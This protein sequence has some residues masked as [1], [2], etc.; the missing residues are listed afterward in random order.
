[1]IFNEIPNPLVFFFDPSKKS[2][3]T[4]ILIKAPLSSKLIVISQKFYNCKRVEY[5]TRI[6]AQTQ[7]RPIH[8][9]SSNPYNFYLT[10]TILLFLIHLHSIRTV[11]N[12]TKM[13]RKKTRAQWKREQTKTFQYQIAPPFP[14]SSLHRP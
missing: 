4:V 6:P 1:M 14:L 8:N 5:I 2:L 7:T 12:P 11:K 9:E 13:F 3:V 10:L